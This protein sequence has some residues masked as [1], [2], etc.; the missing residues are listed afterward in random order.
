MLHALLTLNY[1][2][3]LA[4]LTPLLA[5]WA[6]LPTAIEPAYYGLWSWL[7]GIAGIGVIGSGPR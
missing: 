3:V 6:A 4:W 5:R 2:V 1:G 7:C